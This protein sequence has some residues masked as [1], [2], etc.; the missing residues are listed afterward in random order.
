MLVGFTGEAQR[1]THRAT[2]R[3]QSLMSATEPAV[4]SSLCLHAS[5][6]IGTGRRSRLPL[7]LPDGERFLSDVAAV[8]SSASL[9]LGLPAFG[10]GTFL[11]AD[12]RRQSLICMER[13]RTTIRWSTSMPGMSHAG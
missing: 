11:D 4:G 8:R 1:A 3:L 2:G 7:R 12:S 9:L 10:A 6:T 5:C 13:Q